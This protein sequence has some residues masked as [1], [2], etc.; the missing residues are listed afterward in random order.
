MKFLR[1]KLKK[2]ESQK[3]FKNKRLGVSTLKVTE[4]VLMSNG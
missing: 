2:L 3:R 1:K 4:I